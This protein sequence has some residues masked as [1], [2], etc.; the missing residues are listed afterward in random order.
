M[1]NLNFRSYGRRIKNLFKAPL[2][3]PEIQLEHDVLGSDY[4]SWPVL[5]N[6]LNKKSRVYSFG[7]GEDISFDLALI[8]RYGCTIDGF[9]PTPR[10]Q[11][12]LACQTLPT[13]FRYHD[14]GLSD[15]TDVLR[16]AAPENPSHVSYTVGSRETEF[17]ELPVQPLDI[18]MTLLGDDNID[19]LK[20]D[21]EGS[22]YAVISDMVKKTILP[23]QF[24]VE[25]HHGF[26]GFS[27]DETI[28]AVEQLRKAGYLLYYVSDSHREYGFAHQSFVN[29]ARK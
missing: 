1:N 24:C 6:S 26:F 29:V 17:V 28:R 3:R 13:T 2:H 16:F 9:D 10:C 21:I 7:I 18:C 4:G 22:E 27:S 14:I 23:P 15:S 19:L 20:I 8:E 5:R 12:W 11:A 25:F